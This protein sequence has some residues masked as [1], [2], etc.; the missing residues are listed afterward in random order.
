MDRLLKIKLEKKKSMP[1]FA[2]HDSNTKTQFKSWRKPRGMHNKLRMRGAGHGKPVKIGHGLPLKGV[3]K[4]GL[5]LN[6]VK[7]LNELSKLNKNN[8]SIII[9]NIGMKKKLV[10]IK[11]SE[12]LGFRVANINNIKNYLEEKNKLLE[13]KKN[14]K[15]ER[16]EKKEKS[17]KELEKKAKEKEE[18]PEEKK[19]TTEEKIKEDMKKSLPGDRR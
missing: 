18:K 15:K 10:L 17:K 3:D 6:L 5:K 19:N 7:N 2:R 16:T 14:V 4:H 9:A 11:K 13:Y 1:S 8:D 12:E